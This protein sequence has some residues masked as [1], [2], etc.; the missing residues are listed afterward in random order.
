MSDIKQRLFQIMRNDLSV[1]A[2]HGDNEQSLY[3]EIM[4]ADPEIIAAYTETYM[5]G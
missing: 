2:E 5:E 4:T 3:N 1:M